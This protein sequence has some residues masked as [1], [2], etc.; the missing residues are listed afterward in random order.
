LDTTLILIGVGCII[1]AIIGGGV[2]LVQIELSQVKSLWRQSLLGAFGV[3]LI[4][5]GL[6]S[7]GHLTFGTPADVTPPPADTSKS[8]PAEPQKTNEPEKT[9]EPQK[10]ADATPP[11]PADNQPTTSPP[12]ASSPPPALSAATPYKVGI[13]WC[14]TD[15]GGTTNQAIAARILPALEASPLVSRA[16]AR[17]LSQATN[18]QSSY[19]ITANIVRYDPGE[20]PMADQ[21]ARLATQASG[22][23]FAP[24]HALPGSPSIDYL[25]IFVCAVH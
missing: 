25:S 16:R 24:A 1:G 6:I 22:T 17:P 3:I 13:F 20:A 21:I 18:A 14:V 11:K 12:P 4:L 23:E 15:D 9:G 19:S 2:K 7:G 8:P 10:A 5:W